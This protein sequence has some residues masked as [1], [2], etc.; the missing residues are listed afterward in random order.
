[1]S[2]G[3]PNGKFRAKFRCDPRPGA[4]TAVLNTIKRKIVEICLTRLINVA[5]FQR[6]I[7]GNKSNNNHLNGSILIN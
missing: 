5:N 2:I 3:V 1:M 6:V 7:E 4:I